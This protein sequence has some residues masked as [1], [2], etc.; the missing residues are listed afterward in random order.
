MNVVFQQVASLGVVSAGPTTGSDSTQ[1][2]ADSVPAEEL[3]ELNTL[4]C[5][6]RRSELM[7]ST[8]AAASRGKNIFTRAAAAKQSPHPERLLPCTR[9]PRRRLLRRVG[10]GARPPPLPPLLL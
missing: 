6:D 7:L 2:L 5:T 9:S 10:R 1:A 4:N 8:F 3:T